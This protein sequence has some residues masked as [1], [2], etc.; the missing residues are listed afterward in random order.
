M[1]NK[2]ILLMSDSY[3]SS[4][5]V[6]YPEGAQFVSSYIES[7]GGKWDRTV[8]FGLQMFLKEY[9]ATSITKEDI[10]EAEEVLTAHGEPFNRAGWMH[11]LDKHEGRLPIRIQALPEGTVIETRNVLVQLVNTDPL[12]P[13]LTSFLETALLRAVWYPTTVATNSF[14]AKEV[15]YKALQET[16]DDADLEIGF[17]MHDFGAR[18]VSSGESAAIGGVSHLVNFMGTDTLEGILAARKYYN[19]PMAGFS[20]PATE[21]STITSWGGPDK[22]IEPYRNMLKQFGEAGKMFACVSDSYDIYNATSNLWAGELLQEVKDSGVTVVIRPDSG[23]PTVVPIEI[24]E[25]LMEKVGY[26]TNEKGYKVLP[27]Y[28]R[29]LQGDGI[30][31]DTIKIILDRMKEKG[32]SASN[33][34]FG[35]GGGLLQQIDRDTLKFA[36]KASAI[37]VNGEWRDVFKDPITDKGKRS[38]KGRLALVELFDGTL[39][40]VRESMISTQVNVLQDVFVDGLLVNTTTFAEVRKR[41]ATGIK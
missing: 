37:Q 4:H 28:F 14:A 33:I 24:I 11:I 13:W 3:K 31:V 15:I 22:E 16:S 20:I 40:T 9:L 38:K 39:E 21:H 30:T 23:D 25:L 8:F 34:A 6:Q 5:F 27:Y 17:K 7:R 1:L 29:V 2:N 36:M 12:V 19:E 35:Q 26:E 32:L 18:G 10:D 41:A